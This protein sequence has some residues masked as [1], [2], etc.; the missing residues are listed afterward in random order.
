MKRLLLLL[1][2]VM[3]VCAS[4][5]LTVKPRT[6]RLYY[7]SHGRA[8]MQLDP[9]CAACADTAGKRTLWRWGK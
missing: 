1:A 2:L 3:L 7:D 8:R 6:G 4:V 9:P 5:A